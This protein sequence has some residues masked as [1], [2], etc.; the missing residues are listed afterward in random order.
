MNTVLKVRPAEHDR[1]GE[2]DSF[3]AGLRAGGATEAVLREAGDLFEAASAGQRDIL[4][5]LSSSIL[6]APD[7]RG[8]TTI[9]NLAA[10]RREA[11]GDP[12]RRDLSDFSDSSSRLALRTFFLLAEGAVLAG[13]ADGTPTFNRWWSSRVWR[14]VRAPIFFYV[15]YRDV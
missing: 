14:P 9:E 15:T 6:L 1:R 4:G 11:L 5:K 7:R 3:V 13:N 2:R 12:W 10:A 8:K